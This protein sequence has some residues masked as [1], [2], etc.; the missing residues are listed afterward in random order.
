MNSDSHF[1]LYVINLSQVINMNYIVFDLE[2]N[3]C[4]R[5]KARENPRMPFEIIEIG[6]IKLDEDRNEIDRFSEMVRPLVYPTL[7]YRTREITSLDQ[8]ELRKS[9]TFCPVIRDFLKWCGTDCKFVTWGNL[10]L[11]E[12]Q[13]NMDYYRLANPFPKPLFYCDLQK[14]FSLL[15]SD[16]KSRSALEEAVEFLHIPKDIEF[17]RAF[18]DTYY[19]AEVMKK[20]D[21]DKVKNYESI[22]YHRLPE[23]RKEEIVR[24]FKTYTKYVSRVFPTREEALLDKRVTSLNCPRCNLP[25]RKRINWFSSASNQYLAMGACP[26]HGAVKG[27]IR[28]KKAPEGKVFLVK[29]VKTADEAAVQKIRERQ[30]QIRQRRKERRVRHKSDGTMA[31]DE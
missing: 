6:A 21:F 15:Y 24:N 10:D 9:R 2:W 31:V 16:G 27:K 29:T 12:L 23:N 17:H 8:K 5:G 28:V 11:T 7:H 22:D 4:P 14:M 19:T 26:V 30:S 25:L 1:L 18:D 13:Q 20:M 3:Q